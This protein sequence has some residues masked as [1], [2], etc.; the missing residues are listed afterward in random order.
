MK[1]PRVLLSILCVALVTAVSPLSAGADEEPPAMSFGFVEVHVDCGDHALAAWQVE[2]QAL[3]DVRIVGVE[4]GEHPEYAEAPYYDTAAI[5][6]ERVIL[7]A[8]S[9]AAPDA[10]PSGRTRVATVHV[11]WTGSD[12]PRF[13][14]NL[15]VAADEAG[16]AI[17]AD[18]TLVQGPDS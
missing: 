17:D 16:A 6:R 4:G 9:T 2:V 14:T 5:Q 18:V 8:F 7:A 12:A 13:E 3:G 11:V 1:L 10:L 15:T